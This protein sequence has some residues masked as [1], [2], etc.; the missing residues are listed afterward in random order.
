MAANFKI[1]THHYFKDLH[2]ILEGDF[3]GSSAYELLNILK[4]HYRFA[5][6]VFI[7][8]DAIGHIYPFGTSVF[9]GH[10]GELRPKKHMHLEFTGDHAQELAPEG[11][12]IST[13]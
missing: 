1:K 6:R 13:H 2:L 10:F 7:N 12:N 3:D 9:H 4:K 5:S 8:T 11:N